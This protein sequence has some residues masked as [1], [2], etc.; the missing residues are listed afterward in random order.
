MQVQFAEDKNLVKTHKIVAWDF[1]YRAAR[2]GPW[3]MYARDAARFKARIIEKGSII[4]PIL[5]PEHRE[6]IYQQRFEHVS[7]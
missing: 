5:N 3:E 7:Y 4:A 1:A 6:A 2:K